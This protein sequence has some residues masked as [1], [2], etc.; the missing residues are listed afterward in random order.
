MPGMGTSGRT[1]A[2]ERTAR[3]LYDGCLGI[4]DGLRCFPVGDPGQRPRA[5]ARK[6]VG[7]IPNA[8]E[9]RRLKWKGSG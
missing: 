7:L 2:A 3:D 6:A 4:P 5:R 9:K 1:V 8:C